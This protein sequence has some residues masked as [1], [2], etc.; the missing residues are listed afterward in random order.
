MISDFEEGAG[1]PVVIPQDG[2]AGAW[3]RV[4]ENDVPSFQVAVEAS[5]TSDACDEWAL[6]AT[7]SSAAGWGDRVGLE[8]HFGEDRPNPAL[9]EA[10]RYTGVRFRARRGASHDP[11]SAVRFNLSIPE[12]EG[13]G[14]GGTCVDL[15]E[16]AD[17]AARPCYQHLGRFLQV[18]SNI[19]ADN[20]LSTDWR[21][22]TYCFDR[23]LYPLAPPSNLSN[24]E[25]AALASRVLKLQFFFNQGKDWY[26]GFVPN[27][28]N[29]RMVASLPFGFWVN[30]LEFFEGKCPNTQL[31]F[32]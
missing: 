25:R 26:R 5:E 9:C 3:E 11:N 15:P 4:L 6:H 10:S 14:S 17:K 2:R 32:S 31:G 16:T 23:D 30:D 1:A 29:Q 22:Y 19:D 21:E 7:G 13:P 12:T 20:E 8:I 27:G 18:A 28:D 24:A